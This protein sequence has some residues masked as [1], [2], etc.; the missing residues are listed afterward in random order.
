MRRISIAV[1]VFTLLSALAAAGES[2]QALSVQQRARWRSGPIKIAVSQSLLQVAPNVKWNSNV[3]GAINRAFAAWRNVA[4]VEMIQEVSDKQSV[5]LAGVAGDG[6]SLITIAATPENVLLFKADPDSAAKTRVFVNRRGFISEADIILSPYQQFSTDGTY[7]TFDL[8]STIKHELGH[9]LGLQHSSVVGSV[10]YDVTSKNGVFGETGSAGGM[11]TADDLSSIRD[12]YDDGDYA[13]CC[14][15]L[16]GHLAGLNKNT[17]TVDLWLEEALTGR[18]VAHTSSGVEGG[19]RFGGVETG[20]YNVVAR[21]EGVSGNYS[22]ASIGGATVLNGETASFDHKLSRRPLDFSTELLGKNGIL[23]DSPIKLVRGSS[24]GLYI[25]GK[26]LTS[27]RV[28]LEIGSPYL[29][30]DSASVGD[31]AYDEGF[32]GLR[33]SLNVDAE[34]P[35]GNY[36]ICA[37]STSGS[38][39]CIAGGIV[40]LA[41]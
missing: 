29:T 9:L 1:I 15:I 16:T 30:I 23:S 20:V 31:T 41:R 34:T 19:F 11:L 37:V 35:P 2:S 36:S 12:L 40:V 17:K 32:S 28:K 14:G 18:I 33:F 22:T 21:E 10:M 39:D 7:G 38:R 25:G 26:Q 27:D 3:R 8:E 4:A 5:S 24:Y 13:G 6:V